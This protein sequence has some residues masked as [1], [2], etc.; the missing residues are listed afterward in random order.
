MRALKRLRVIAGDKAAALPRVKAHCLAKFSLALAALDPTLRD[1]GHDV[2]ETEETAGFQCLED[3]EF[4]PDVSLQ[5]DTPQPAVGHATEAA[6][7]QEAAPQFRELAA[8]R[9]PGED[10]ADEEC[11]V[12]WMRAQLHSLQAGRAFE[13][14]AYTL[15]YL[16]EV[17]EEVQRFAHGLAQQLRE[18]NELP[19]SFYDTGRKDIGI[20]SN[21]LV[22]IWPTFRAA[23][24]TNLEELRAVPDAALQARLRGQIERAGGCMNR[25]IHVWVE[26]NVPRRWNIIMDMSFHVLRAHCTLE[27]LKQLRKLDPYIDVAELEGLAHFKGLPILAETCLPALAPQSAAGR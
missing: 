27:L 22:S 15:W 10:A 3:D 25:L 1:F 8:A 12:S 5:H 23:V 21:N 20:M 16:Y 24:A 19:D 4:E 11:T 26:A 7:S 17:F 18:F 6:E 9:G 14:N 13:S 2:P